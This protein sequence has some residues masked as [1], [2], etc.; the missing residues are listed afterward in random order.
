MMVQLKATT[1]VHTIA[2]AGS[3]NSMMVQLKVSSKQVNG[4]LALCFN[5]MMVQLKGV[6]ESVQALENLFQFHD[7]TIKSV[8]PEFDTQNAL[9]FQFHDGT[10]KRKQRSYSYCNR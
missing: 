6:T 7:G 4:A 2:V 1:G 8:A 3:F 10:I 5:S 9:K